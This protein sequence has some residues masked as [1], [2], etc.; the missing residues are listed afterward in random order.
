MIT[1]LFV[2]SVFPWVPLYRL[3]IK[4]QLYDS[5]RKKEGDDDIA[6]IAHLIP[7]HTPLKQSYGALS[8]YPVIC[9]PL[10]LSL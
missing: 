6:S 9:R 3:T 10:S 4:H 7:Y 1:D 5:I 2:D 8:N